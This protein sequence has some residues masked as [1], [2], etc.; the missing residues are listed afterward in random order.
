MKVTTDGNSTEALRYVIRVHKV[1]ISTTRPEKFTDV[2]D[3]DN[4]ESGIR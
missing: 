3:D 1:K 2:D 4:R